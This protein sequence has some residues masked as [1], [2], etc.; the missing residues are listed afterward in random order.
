MKFTHDPKYAQVE[1]LLEY[2]FHIAQ[3]VL[4]WANPTSMSNKSFKVYHTIDSAI[5]ENTKDSLST[6]PSNQ[7]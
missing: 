1:T 7:E 2:C 5:M 3:K 4:D 6:L